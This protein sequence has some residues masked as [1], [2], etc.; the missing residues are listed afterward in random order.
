MLF[1]DNAQIFLNR[2]WEKADGRTHVSDET[3][4]M[5][6]NDFVPKIELMNVPLWRGQILGK[7]V[8][9]QIPNLSG[10]RT[11]LMSNKAM[12]MERKHPKNDLN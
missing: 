6:L 7:S 11:D 2:L 8:S 10:G 5:C 1:G 3:T 9:S 4:E 12:L